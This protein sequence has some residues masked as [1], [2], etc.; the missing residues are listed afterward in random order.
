MRVPNSPICSLPPGLLRLLGDALLGIQEWTAD[1]KIDSIGLRTLPV[2]ARTAHFLCEPALD[3]LWD[4]LPDFGV[5]VYLLPRDA[6]DMET[7]DVSRAPQSFHYV[8]RQNLYCIYSGS[9]PS[10]VH[11][12]PLTDEEFGRLAYYTP[13]VK[14]VQELCSLFP[15]RFHG[16]ITFETSILA[17]LASRWST[18]QPLF[19][20]LRVVRLNPAHDQYKVYYRYFHVLFG[21]QLRHISSDATAFSN[22]K[23]V[24]PEDYRQ[25]LMRLQETAP[26]L[27]RF[28]LKVDAEPYSPI[29]LSAM[30]S[31]IYS[32]KHLVSVRTG[33]LP[34]D[35]PTIRYLAA[36]PHLE[37][38]EIRPADSISPRDLHWLGTT[39]LAVH[40]PN[41]REVH[42]QHHVAPDPLA[43]ILLHIHSARLE[44]IHITAVTQDTLIPMGHALQLLSVV[45]SRN[46]SAIIKQLH[47]TIPV[48]RTS[49]VAMIDQHLEPLDRLGH[50]THLK[51]QFHCPVIVTEAALARAAEAWPNIRELTIYPYFN[52]T[53]SLVECRYSQPIYANLELAWLT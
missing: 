14:R 26:L 2:L 39:R 35:M 1:E 12:P 31:A 48:D 30:Y 49:D 28:E 25:M 18:S 23:D 42:L 22:S 10:S 38:M 6:W 16:Y 3:A 47:L 51:L 27:T 29:I 17:A 20:N 45:L 46:G 41:P 52:Q 44:T 19:H 8:A 53:E 50:L 13:R 21:A 40:F 37:I 7:V 32:F 43:T 34:M 4:T 15:S 9:H 11:Y 24:E 5:S 36:L 33:A